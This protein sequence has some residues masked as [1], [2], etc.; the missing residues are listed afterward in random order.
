MQEPAPKDQFLR[1]LESCASD[2]GFL[3]DFYDRFLST[4]AEI[5]EKFRDT[6]METQ[7]QMLLRSLRLSAG[8][9]VGDSDS[10][11]ELRER[12]ESH[13]RHHLNI[14]PILYEF[15]LN[16]VIQTAS[17]YDPDWNCDVE[18]AWQTVLG[19]VVHQMQQYY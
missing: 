4:S 14:Q 18:Q 2:P 7:K 19:H 6:D 11:R 8:A 1:S 13:D 17:E 9:T 10:L 16:T 12:A 3:S 15:W 5:R